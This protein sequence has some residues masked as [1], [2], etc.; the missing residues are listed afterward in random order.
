MGYYK[1]SLE[2][3]YEEYMNRASISLLGRQAT[4]LRLLVDAYEV[5]LRFEKLLEMMKK[6]PLLIEDSDLNYME[7]ADDYKW[8]KPRGEV[9]ETIGSTAE[10]YG[11][12]EGSP[13]EQ[14]YANHMKDVLGSRLDKINS[15]RFNDIML[16]V[17][18]TPQVIS[19]FEFNL[20]IEENIK[21]LKET[22]RE[23]NNF[24]QN[25]KWNKSDYAKVYQTLHDIYEK[26]NWEDV[27]V[28]SDH[29]K[30]LKEM[31]VEPDLEDYEQRRREL[32]LELFKTGFLDVMKRNVHVPAKDDL[33]FGLIKDEEMI[34]DLTDTLKWYASFKKL[35][36][37]DKDQ[38][39]RL[40]EYAA[41]G[42]YIYDNNIPKE[43]YWK[44]FHFA[45]LMEIVQ[46][47]MEWLRHPE[48]KP[49]NDEEAVERFVERVKHI[50]LKAE[51]DNGLQKPLTARGHKGTYIYNV[52]GKGFCKV[53]DV[54]QQDYEKTII[55][56]L[57]GATA[58]QAESIKYVAP[59]I[60]CVLDTHLYSEAQMPKN[61][62][63]E[64]FE[65]VYGKDTSATTKMSNT[66][67][68]KEAERL[69]EAVKK[70]METLKN[71]E[72]LGAQT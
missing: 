42:L 57:E 39:F 69:F 37:K 26:S 22:L 59:F 60:G 51:E 19:D 5:R 48:K 52:D 41:L 30:W 40:N 13:F 17:I 23:I 47:E 4:M 45:S 46:Q 6:R 63:K 11:F 65:T 14:T 27:K 25:K 62:F 28:K 15:K 55:A 10:V 53:M 2:L 24:K 12:S 7:W 31:V 21:Q 16:S 44:F 38:Q 18:S 72:L 56:Y 32:L 29:R 34:A 58:E 70:V 36:P 9:S 67:P 49:R 35:C 71:G 50:M 33:N 66:K 61:A 43:A 68:S 64:V 1:R 20:A 3:L 8:I 54:L